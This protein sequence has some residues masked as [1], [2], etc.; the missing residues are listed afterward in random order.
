MALRADQGHPYT[1]DEVTDLE[2]SDECFG[3]PGSRFMTRKEGIHLTGDIEHTDTYMHTQIHTQIHTY[4][5]NSN[6]LH[7]GIKVKT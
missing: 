5:A 4:L 2:F 6:N 1:D 7:I 3:R